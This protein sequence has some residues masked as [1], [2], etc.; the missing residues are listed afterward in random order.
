MYL[1]KVTS[2]VILFIVFSS[3]TPQCAE[4]FSIIFFLIFWKAL[5]EKMCARKWKTYSCFSESGC[6]VE[7][8]LAVCKKGNAVSLLYFEQFEATLR[9]DLDN[10]CNLFISAIPLSKY[11]TSSWIPRMI[12]SECVFPTESYWTFTTSLQSVA[13]TFPCMIGYEIVCNPRDVYRTC[14]DTSLHEPAKRLSESLREGYHCYQRLFVA[15][16]YVL[17]YLQ[18]IIQSSRDE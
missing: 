16:S 3:I 14:H 18:F 12:T 7:A 1:Y 9:I 11:H 17:I 10:L 6:V 13:V 5:Y 2:T 8:A 4:N 15:S